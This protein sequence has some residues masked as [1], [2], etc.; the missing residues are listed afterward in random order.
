MYTSDEGLR[1][2]TLILVLVIMSCLSVA[3]LGG[4]FETPQLVYF[5]YLALLGIVAMILMT[6]ILA[7]GWLLVALLCHYQ[8]MLAQWG[9]E[10]PGH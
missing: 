9:G 1:R 10:V 2:L 6:A 4:I 5:W 8:R 3:A 7:A